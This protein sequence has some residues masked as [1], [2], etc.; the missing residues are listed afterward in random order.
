MS[1]A[2]LG[3]GEWGVGVRKG[4]RRRRAVTDS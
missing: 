1:W 2:G 3:F 4:R